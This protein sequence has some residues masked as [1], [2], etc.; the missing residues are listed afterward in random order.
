M[1]I[2]GELLAPYAPVVCLIILI[3]TLILFATE[4][5]KSGI[6]AIACG[7][8]MNLCGFITNAEFTSGFSN[9]VTIF[10][11]GIAMVGTAM[12]ETG[13]AS[14]LGKKLLSVVK[15]DERGTIVVLFTL[16]AILSAFLNNTSCVV[17]GLY[18]SIAICQSSEGR[19]KVRNFLMPMGIAGVCGGGA[20]MIGSTTQL[21]IAALLPDMGFEMKMWD[22]AKPGVIV[23]LIFIVWYYFFGYNIMQKT[24]DFPEPESMKDLNSSALKEFDPKNF[25]GWIPAIILVGCIALTLLGWNIAIVGMMGMC[26][27]IMTGSISFKRAV[28]TTDWNVFFLIAGGVGFA[29]GVKN[30][31]TADMVANW[32]VRVLGAA[33]PIVYLVIFTILCAIMTNVMTNIGTALIMTPIAAAVAAQAGFSAYPLI[34]CVI[35]GANMPYSTPV[36][37]SPITMTMMG[38]YRF[39]DYT[40]V[41]IIPNIVAAIALALL[42]PIFWPL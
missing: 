16:V 1:P 26:L 15:L 21:S 8:V 12:A 34:L 38:G 11:L 14:Y 32:I 23:P 28:E 3:I 39:K 7:I 35:W 4:V 41:N 9:T 36:G 20:S 33:P 24:F 19:F 42:T 2:F 40:R 13:C 29:A 22:L 6:T 31:G 30:A 37:A 18:L 25:K 17:I 5:F 27:A 10:C